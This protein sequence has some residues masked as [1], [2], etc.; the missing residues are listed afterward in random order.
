MEHA[1]DFTVIFC[2]TWRNSVAKVMYKSVSTTE[3]H[4]HVTETWHGTILLYALFRLLWIPGNHATVGN[5]KSEK[6]RDDFYVE[7]NR[8]VSISCTSRATKFW[9]DSTIHFMSGI[10]NC[11]PVSQTTWTRHCTLLADTRWGNGA[12]ENVYLLTTQV[13]TSL[14]LNRSSTCTEAVKAQRQ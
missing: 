9:R 14:L 1:A 7:S 10:R 6:E 4:S 12:D 13:T 3:K 5:S 8:G 2:Y 11:S